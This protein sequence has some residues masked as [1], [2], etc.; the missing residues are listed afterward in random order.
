MQ[1]H[2]LLAAGTIAAIFLLAACNNEPEA[3][4][5]NEYDP[6]AEQLKKAPPVKE[7][8]PA[9][10]ASRTYRC[11]DNSLFYVDFYTN[12]TALLRTVRGGDAVTLQAEGGNP[13]FVADGHSVSD[14]GESVRIT[15]PGK[16]N[17]AC[18]T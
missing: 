2:R 17:L 8:P 13:P 4:S 7:L 6:M 11:S 10:A 16:N 15:A 18:H 5:I 14:N 3:I 12:N 1:K 9:I